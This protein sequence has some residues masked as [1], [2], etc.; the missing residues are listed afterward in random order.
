VPPGNGVAALALLET[1][2]LFGE[3]HYLEAVDRT[4][5]WARQAMEQYPAGHCTLL[6]ALQA[7]LDPSS[8]IIVRGP[9]D[10]LPP[11]L[12]LANRGYRPERTVYA[13]PYEG[14]SVVPPYLRKVVSA[15]LRDR[16]VAYVCEGNRCSLPL[17]DLQAFKAALER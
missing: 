3:A 16:V 11:W 7:A 1:G 14:V 10:Q 13:I 8:Q 12:E 5:V 9:T 4:I 17:E 15:D 2:H 6:T